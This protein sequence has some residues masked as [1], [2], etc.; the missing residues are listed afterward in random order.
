M[1]PRVSQ[2]VTAAGSRRDLP[3]GTVTFVFTDIEGSTKLAHAL[4][5]DRW[6][7]VLVQHAAIVRRA[8]STHEGVEVR[9][10]GDSF[11]LAF[12]TARQAVAAATDAQRALAA[13]QWPHGVGVRVRIGMHTGENA[14]PGDT[15]SGADY[16]GYDVHRAARVSGAAH[17]G[18]VLLSS[19][20]RTLLGEELPAGVTLRDVGEHRL[21]D[22]SQPDRLYQLVIDGL[23]ADF[24]PLRTLSAV[25]NN[26]PVQLTSFVG[27]RREIA[28]ARDL[29]AR[30][31]LLTLVGPGGTGKTRLSLELGALVMSE[32]PGGVWPARLAA[33]SDAALVASAVAQALGL[34][35]PPA[36][37]PL[38]HV[39]DHLRER[40]AL[41]ILDNF[42]QV[43]EAASD[44][45]RILL[46]C[47]RVKVMVTTRI[48]LRITGEQ[49]YPVPPLTLP[50][51]GDVPDVGE[52]V[53]SEA[54]QLFIER[55]RSARPDFMLTTDNSHAVVGIV[56]QLDGLPLA[57]ELAAARLKVLP[58][59]AILERLA[60]GIGILQSSARDLPARQQTLRGAI[61]WSYDLLDTGLR[62]L[63]Q[64]L[65]VFRGG[66]ALEQIEQ[67][68][69]PADE[70]GR[71]V[72]DGVAELVD[73]S[74]LRRADTDEPRFLMLETIREFARERLEESGEAREIQMR[75]A[76]AYLSLAESTAPLLFGAR[77]KTLLDVLELEQGN[78]RTALDICDQ[79]SCADRATCACPPEEHEGQGDRIEISLR[80][81]GALWRFWQMRGHLAEGR[82][83]TE[84]ILA[85]PGAEDHRDAH[86]R[87]L[88]AAGGITYWQGDITATE[89]HYQQRLR[90]ARS[91]GDPVAVANALYDLSFVHILSERTQEVGVALL[92]EA[93]AS[94][95]A[96]GDRA[97]VAKTLWAIATTYFNRQDWAKA[98]EI[99]DEV[100]HTFRELDNRFGLA[101]ALHSLGVG[102]IRLGDMGEARAALAEGLELFRAAGDVSGV[103]LFFYDFAELAAARHQEERAL[104]LFGAGQA[105]KERTG[106]QLADYLREENKPF[107]LEIRALLDRGDPQ[108]RAA[109]AAEGAALSQ[110]QAIAFALAERVAP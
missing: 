81:S 69:G 107:S 110:E 27:R 101:W 12:R 62:R 77:Q 109:L 23:P 54:M 56:A 91:T 8:A 82:Q 58:P 25:P 26:L 78:L 83:R 94:F 99:L 55:A 93:L 35:V 85:V 14:R 20:T 31:R 17:G 9:T 46:E 5:T 90:V 106:T 87:A 53:R 92:N 36:R 7:D 49:E 100:V 59:Q 97:G 95:R 42:E 63:F 84:R 41:L 73:Q 48:V 24:A 6:R 22:L 51:P 79:G 64:R 66:G 80:L 89:R 86:L 96:A 70:I 52:L 37:A 75:H 108:L 21:K 103:V 47:P 11:F 88:E 104:R 29:L 32:F 40:E 74:L 61:A 102:K 72:L 38:D 19:A 98:V 50:D 3:S 57:I 13:Q 67:V 16:V 39:V 33:V 43:V 44:V 45:S 105:L 4:G 10:E 68:C 34:V 28:G 71:D 30:T 65:S 18:Q 1:M 76:R 2:V 15:A 60:S